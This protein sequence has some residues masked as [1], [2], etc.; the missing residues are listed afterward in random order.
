MGMMPLLAQEYMGN[1]LLFVKIVLTNRGE[2]SIVKNW[3]VCLI[4]DGKPFIYPIAA[5][6]P[7]GITTGTI[8]KITPEDS[9]VDKA[10]RVPIEH[11]H[12][13][14]GWVCFKIPGTE[15]IKSWT[16]KKEIP[17]GSIRFKDYLDHW[18]SF[19]FDGGG[20]SAE[21]QDLYVP[22]AH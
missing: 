4:L 18:Y 1:T 7:Q 21:I 9:L 15:L 6:P 10:I 11:A 19:E 13:A 22:G 2:A 5:I 20:F 3:D 8:E 12:T 17:K 16:S 14:G